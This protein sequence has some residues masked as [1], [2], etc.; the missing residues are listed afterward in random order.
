MDL[1]GAVSKKILKNFAK[2]AQDPSELEKIA[3]SKDL[4]Q[5]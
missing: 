3:A 2:F 4:F 5:S 1:R